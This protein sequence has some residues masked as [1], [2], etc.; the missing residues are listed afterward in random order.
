MTLVAAGDLF[1]VPPSVL[2]KRL[3]Q[4]KPL[5][6]HKD[7]YQI[8]YY[9][10]KKG[11]IQYVDKNNERFMKLTKKG[12]LEALLAK[13][14]I[15]QKPQKWDGKWRLIIFDI[16]ERSQTKRDLFR[17]LLKKNGFMLVQQSVYINPYPLN[18]EAV[19]YLKKTGLMQFIRIMKVEEIDSDIDLRKRFKL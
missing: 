1:F 3:W 8:V 13:A 7:F 16:P 10:A 9:L 4:G 11:L 14:R 2:R 15:P 19:E 17:W 12:Q 18:R 6:D 5:G